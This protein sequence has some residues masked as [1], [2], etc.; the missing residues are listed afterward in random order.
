MNNLKKEFVPYELA[1]EL[2]QIGFDKPCLSYFSAYQQLNLCGFENMSD[3][4]FVSAP[5]YSQCFRWF[6]EKYKLHGEPML[7][8]GNLFTWE[9]YEIADSE[10]IG[11]RRI[12]SCTP[13]SEIEFQT[14]EEAEQ[15]CLIRLIEIVKEKQI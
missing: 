9:C 11:V 1:L 7:I 4:G 2:K 14:Y 6:R 5:T 10:M 12:S 3:R 8:K 15:A 13:T